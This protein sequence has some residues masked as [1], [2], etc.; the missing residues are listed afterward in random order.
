[1][2]SNRLKMLKSVHKSKPNKIHG[3][4]L[5][6]RGCAGRRMRRCDSIYEGGTW[7][8][9]LTDVKGRQISKETD[10]TGRRAHQ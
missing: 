5:T 7:V 8:L 2:K 1:M 10:V 3:R 6:C 9:V 4:K